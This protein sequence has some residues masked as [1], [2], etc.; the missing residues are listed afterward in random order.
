MFHYVKDIGYRNKIV[1]SIRHF[2]T[3]I[4]FQVNL[5]TGTHLTLI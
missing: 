5:V 3:A 1:Q 4:E 2:K